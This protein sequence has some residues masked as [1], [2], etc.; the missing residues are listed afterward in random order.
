MTRAVFNPHQ[1]QGALPASV[2]DVVRSG[3]RTRE[4]VDLFYAA[5]PWADGLL[6]EDQDLVLGQNDLEHKLG[7]KLRGWEVVKGAASRADFFAYR[8]A[9]VALADNA[10]TDVVFNAE[11]HDNGGVYDTS[12]GRFTAP[13]DG[14]YQFST[15]LYGSV[16]PD[17][18]RLLAQFYRNS[19]QWLFGTQEVVG[20]ADRPIV[21]ANV[22]A[23]RLDKD[24]TVYVRAFQDSG[25]AES[26]IGTAN[27]RNTYFSGRAID[28]LGD[29][30]DELTEAEQGRTLR[31]H[32]SRARTVTLKVW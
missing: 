12:T 4:W 13:H 7:R 9:N 16:F 27:A 1:P 15:T 22:A 30:Q 3:E 20:G 14:L 31:L 17:G 26:L 32:S 2:D 28:E 11:I 25:G 18:G 29:G 6:L 23:V 10:Y 21:T 8:D 24:D 5:T 19:A